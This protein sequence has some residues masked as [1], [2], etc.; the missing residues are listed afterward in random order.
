MGIL[1]DISHRRKKGGKVRFGVSVC[2]Q[3]GHEFIIATVITY[4]CNLN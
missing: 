3:V 2:G 1:T 4:T